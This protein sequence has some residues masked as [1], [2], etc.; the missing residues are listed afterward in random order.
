MDQHRAEFQ[1]DRM[2]RVLAVS[3]S[4]YWHWRRQEGRRAARATAEQALVD[5][6]RRIHDE[7]RKTYGSPRITCALDRE[8]IRCNHKRVA[9]LMQQYG[10][11]AKTAK[12]YRVT[13]RASKDRRALPSDLV[14]RRFVASEPNRLWTSDLTYLWTR[15]G[16]FYLAVIVDVWNRKVVGYAM[17]DRLTAR[18][19][20]AALDNALAERPA[21]MQG[22]MVFHSDRGSQ[23][24]SNEVQMVLAANGI[25]Q[26]VGSS[27]YDNAISETFFHT[28]KTELTDDERYETFDQ[29]RRSIFEYI[30]VFYNR[31]RLHSSL[32]YRTPE[33]VEQQ[34]LTSRSK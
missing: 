11:R 22:V 7:S 14:E 15:E 3:R 4:S 28:L 19:V 20:R 23:Y 30:R 34:Y 8:A 12:R 17:S 5:R 1:L 24:T 10:I 13:T 18:L 29:A 16:W 32:G 25:S 9:K 31:K 27:C 33:E 21:V 2:C 6:I 26:S